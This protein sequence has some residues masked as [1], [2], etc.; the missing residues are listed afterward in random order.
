MS[1]YHEGPEGQQPLPLTSIEASKEL[2]GSIQSNAI[3]TTSINREWFHALSPGEQR[4]SLYLAKMLYSQPIHRRDVMKLGAQLPLLAK[5]PKKIKQ[6]LDL[7]AQALVEKDHPLLGSFHYEE[8]GR[9]QSDLIVFVRKSTKER[10][11][12]E[13]EGEGQASEHSTLPALANTQARELVVYFKRK[14]FGIENAVPSA[15]EHTQAARLISV[16][17][18]EKAKHIVDFCYTE[19]QKTNYPLQFFGGVVTYTDR[20]LA[21]Y[22]EQEKAQE[23]L[24]AKEARKQKQERRKEK[25]RQNNEELLAQLSPDDRERLFTQAQEEVFAVNPIAKAHPDGPMTQAVVRAAVLT[26]LKD[27]T[28]RE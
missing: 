5:A 23:R 13:G 9:G 3:I 25:A 8:K 10:E 21:H 17:G 11:A 2:W 7:Y 14:F 15:K 1:T 26:K 20:A 19:T 27:R 6:Q 18:F 16:H 4:L 22:D 24:K 28:R 12:S